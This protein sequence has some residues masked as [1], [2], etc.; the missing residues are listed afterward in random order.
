MISRNR[1]EDPRCLECELAV[2]FVDIEHATL[3]S[4]VR[5]GFGFVND[6][7]YAVD[8]QDPGKRQPAEP[9]T[10]DCN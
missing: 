4:R 2:V 6:R 5:R 10:D 7:G 9:R 1:S 3:R 8:M